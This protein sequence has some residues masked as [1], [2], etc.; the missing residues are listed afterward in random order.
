MTNWH[1][2]TCEYPPQVGGVGDY[3][4]L[5]AGELRG[6]GDA[7]EVWAPAFDPGTQPQP[8]RTLGEFK[9]ADLLCTDHELE[10]F[11]SP[12]TLLVQWVPH[13]YGKRGVN[14]GFCN[15]IASRARKGDRVCLMIH[16]PYVERSQ[17]SWKLR[18]VSWLQRRMI[19][20]LLSVATRVFISIPAWENYL[21]VYAPPATRFE[22]LPIPATIP[23]QL[24]TTATADI[25]AQISNDSPVLGHLGTYSAEMC[26]I[27]QPTLLKVLHDN[28]NASVLLLG[29]NS[30]RFTAS[31]KAHAPAFA[32]RIYGTGI[33][34]D[35]ALSHHIGACDLMLQPY[36]DGLSSRR[37]SLMNVLAHGVAVISNT[38]HLTENFWNESIAAAL[39]TVGEP[40][41]LAALCSKFLRDHESR[42]ALA[43]AGLSFY[44]ARFDWPIVM[45]ILRSSP[46]A[47]LSLDAITSSNQ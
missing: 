39:A 15:W 10:K 44:H 26:Q 47:H 5:L 36:A 29:K 9:P 27:L 25:R 28:V 22:W 30:D 31:L 13:G 19:R 1:I 37:T 8:H 46:D 14:L 41:Q 21:R 7:V 20:K 38:G 18:A 2:I 35:A 6:A 11:P 45:R 34:S 43:Q 16:E 33:Q 24:D 4:R 23:A 42:A 32:S 40:N 3:T 17:K 12:R